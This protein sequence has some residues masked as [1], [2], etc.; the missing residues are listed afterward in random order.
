MIKILYYKKI[1][2]LNEEMGTQEILTNRKI[3]VYKTDIA[4][5]IAKNRVTVIFTEIQVGIAVE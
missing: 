5:D 3:K 4:A 1:F 2:N